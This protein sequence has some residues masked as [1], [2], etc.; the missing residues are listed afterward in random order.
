MQ[1]P[2]LSLPFSRVYYW[3]IT[4]HIHIH[5]QHM[6]TYLAELGFSKMTRLLRVHLM[7][8]MLIA[9][10]VLLKETQCINIMNGSIRT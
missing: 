3:E 6:H 5:V 1:Y 7:P 2:S 10:C 4:V 9:H 8:Q